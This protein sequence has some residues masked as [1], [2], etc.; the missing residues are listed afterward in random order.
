MARRFLLTTLTFVALLSPSIFGQ[1]YFASDPLGLRGPAISNVERAEHEW[2]LE[3]TEA[4]ADGADVEERLYR[5][6]ELVERT[7]ETGDANGIT[8]QAFH[9]GELVRVERTSRRGNLLWEE[10]YVS[11][12]LA[13]RREY[14]YRDGVLQTRRV[15]E[16]DGRVLV[17]ERYGYWQ[18]GSLRR[19]DRTGPLSSSTLSYVRGRLSRS[20]RREG[21]PERPRE[22]V[23]EYD[24][25]GRITR[26]RVWENEE[27]VVLEEREY[28]G[29]SP[30]AAVQLIVIDEEGTRRVERYD[31][32]GALVASEEGTGATVERSSER[33]YED[34]VL[35]EER[36]VTDGVLRVTNYLYRESGEL[37][38]R[39]VTEDGALVL[40][41]EYPPE[42]AVTRVETI[43]RGGEPLLRVTYEGETRVRE[44]VFQAGEIVRS[45]EFGAP[46]EESP[47]ETP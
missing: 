3:V 4:A 35:V 12:E 32:E 22:E 18:D 19:I 9:E 39:R 2:V 24:E 1:R 42:G 28:W 30:D 11:G 29:P 31:Q 5:D 43:Y 17:E 13:E 16:P 40:E 25:L 38:R 37:D 41:V 7:L 47:E 23:F 26:R 27:L 34:G 45:R 21:S 36:D 15:L 20:S 44:S 6:G 10:R 8:M 33:I 46:E 14:T